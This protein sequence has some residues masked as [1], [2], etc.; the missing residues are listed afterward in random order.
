LAVSSFAQFTYQKPPKAILDVLNVPPTPMGSLNPARTWMVLAQGV[1][2]PSIADLSQP[3]LR[4]AGLRINPRTNG[5]HNP[6]RVIALTLKKLAG[7]S[8]IPIK[9]PANANVSVPRWSPDS[10]K[11]AFANTTPTGIELWL[12]D[13]T[14]AIHKVAGVTLNAATSGGRGGG[15]FQW[16]DNRTMALLLVPAG[17]G[18]PPP[19][20]TVPVGP[21]VQESAGKA[22]GVATFEDM[23]KDEH[24][25]ALLEYYGTAQLA[26]L[27]TTTGKVTHVGKAAIFTN[28]D[29][30]PDGKL[31]LIERV[32]KPFSYLHTLNMFPMEIEVWDHTGKVVHKVVS[33]PLEDHTP[34]EGVIT[35]PR[36]IT[37]RP[38]DAATLYWVEAL[39]E[40]NPKNKVPFR[41]RVMMLKAPFTAPP[42]EVTKTA[43][44]LQRMMWGEKYVLISD[45]ERNRRWTRTF[46]MDPDQPGS[47]MRLI[48]ERN[49]QDRYKDP[50]QP[51]MRALP[52][53][54]RIIQQAGDTIFLTGQGATPQGDRPFLNRFNLK[55]GATEPIFRCGDVGYESVTALLSDDGSKFMASHE[56]PT[57]PPNYF[58]RTADGKATAFTNFPDRAPQLRQIK[59]QLVKYKRE[60]GVDLSFTLYLPP[61]YKEGTRLPTIVWAYPYEFNDAATASQ[62]SGSTQRFTQISG[63]S[64]LFL[65]LAGYAVLDNAAM[66]VIGDSPETVND[67]YI[68]QVV[69]DAKAAIDKAT[70]MGVTDPDRV[71]VGGH[72]YGAFMT[73]N[74][75][76]HSD[77]FRAG[78]ARS[79]AYNRTL[80]PFGFQS[81]RRTFWEARDTYLAMSPFLF[82]D[83]IKAPLLMI[84]GEAD[85][86]SGTFPIQSERMYQA[87]RGNGGTV[88]LVLLPFEAHGYSARESTEHTLWEMVTWFDKYVKNAPPRK[89]QQKAAGG[90]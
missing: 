28:V 89:A 37:W 26:L 30:S 39:D 63:I 7:G 44:R 48:W 90:N 20:P 49:N 4:L 32:H 71:G 29:P 54:Q 11:F 22:V 66:P 36:S 70:E 5:P 31:I 83:K 78:C 16:I 46:L 2:Y 10:T 9:L 67:T 41:D 84:H 81:E 88:R 56:S 18:A 75:L 21:A 73:A 3:M 86:N 85:S 82:A 57:E 13:T 40:G 74:L 23:L 68:K 1:R 60:D 33:R 17:R 19:E 80:T 42:T 8:E 52:N 50:G 34:M 62:V 72:S 59:K 12:G 61:D 65:V 43:Q 25:E 6:P 77:L 15:D 64:Q 14:G 35:G 24:D 45:F 51:V 69:M 58:I 47:P 87:V 53:G 79:G 27:D 38:T 55:T 76:A